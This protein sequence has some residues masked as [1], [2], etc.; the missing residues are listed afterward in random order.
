MKTDDAVSKISRIR[1]LANQVIVNELEKRGHI[2]LVS[3]HGGILVALLFSGEM[4]RTEISNKINRE[5]STVTTLLKKL[6]KLGYI[7]SRTNE[8]DARSTIISLSEKG[9][10]MK[11]D[12][13]EISERLF[14]IQYSN[15]NNEQ[16]Q[17]FQEGLETI[18]QNF[19]SQK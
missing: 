17:F 14:E 6:E 11:N 16:I 12:F 18:Y 7:R 19:L 1:D 2:G 9:A 3:S 4:T 15:M 8:H 13:I 10:L 5:R